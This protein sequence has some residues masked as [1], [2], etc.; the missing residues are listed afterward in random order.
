[1]IGGVAICGLGGVSGAPARGE[2]AS[3]AR[4]VGVWTQRAD[5]PFAVQEIYPTAYRKFEPRPGSVK[6]IVRS[7]LVNA[8]G[9]TDDP[10]FA[11]NVT[12]EV[13]IYDP[14]ADRWRFGPYLPA[15]MHHVGL[16]ANSGF[17]FA[18][19]GFLRDSIGGW[20]MQERVWRLDDLEA[21]AWTPAP[22]LPIPQAETVAVSL[23]G[24]VHV[25]G[26]RSPAGS[27]N[28]EWR[29]HIDT[30]KHWAFIAS[31]NRWKAMAPLPAARNSAAGA[32]Y[33]GALYVIG[34]RTVARGNSP[35]VD[36]YDPV[37]DRWQRAAPLP[38]S[39]RPEAPLGQGGLAAAVW[40]GF[41]YAFGGEWFGAN[42]GR[43][44]VYADV[45]EYDPRED[46]WRAV[47]EMPR[48]RHGLGAVA[49]EDGIY[50]LGGAAEVGGSQTSRALDR[51]VI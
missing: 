10:R 4:P 46:K 28:R 7:L 38:K 44:G 41:I 39:K 22:A 23:N 15:P 25:V 32:V 47:A 19:G 8:G 6:P 2:I 5:M 3:T 30:D 34:G 21:G 1:M 12:D 14:D 18:I 43:G 17:I 20:R 27:V 31:E 42:P 11:N 35:Q 13:I 9:L 33:R 50:V 24:R 37:A 36:I 49:L 51:F 29:D 48:P 45:F 40:N 26:G 16:V